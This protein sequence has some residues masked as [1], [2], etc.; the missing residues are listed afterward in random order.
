M[1]LY[2]GSNPWLPTLMFIIVIINLPGNHRTLFTFTRSDPDL[3][4][5]AWL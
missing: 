2:L 4:S 3:D 1:E 5:L